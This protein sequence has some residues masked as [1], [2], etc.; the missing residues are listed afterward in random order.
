MPRTHTIKKT[1]RNLVC[2]HCGKEIPNICNK[3]ILSSLQKAPAGLSWNML[4]KETKLAK[5]T[6]S[7]HLNDLIEKRKVQVALKLNSRD[8]I[9]LVAY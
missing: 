6:L 4:L 3:A 7:I 2:P 5:G 1:P 9:Y 8:R